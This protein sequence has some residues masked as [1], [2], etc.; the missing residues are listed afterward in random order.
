[1]HAIHLAPSATSIKTVPATVRF[2]TPRLFIT[3][4]NG[5]VFEMARLEI[6]KVR[7]PD[8]SEWLCALFTLDGM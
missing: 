5:H 1:M 6:F 3:R 8:S 7:G 4:T 2:K